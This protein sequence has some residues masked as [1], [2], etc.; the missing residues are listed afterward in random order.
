MDENG[1]PIV[2]IIVSHSLRTEPMEIFVLD[3]HTNISCT[4]TIET[5]HVSG[6][7]FLKVGAQTPVGKVIQP[8]KE[9]FTVGECDFINSFNCFQILISYT[10]CVCHT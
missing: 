2:N 8:D 5:N 6:E 7:Y 3:C 9:A 4:H 1:F 10:P